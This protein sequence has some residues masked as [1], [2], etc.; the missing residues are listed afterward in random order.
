MADPADTLQGK[1]AS[2]AGKPAQRRP[3]TNR[4][5]R[6]VSLRRIYDSALRLFV[7][8]GY[9]ATTVNDIAA[10]AGLTKGGVYFYIEKKEHL[11][12][13]ML[14]SVAGRYIDDILT[15]LAKKDMPPP[16]K[17]VAFVHSQVQFA[18]AH[19]HEVMLLVMS[20][21]EFAKGGSELSE[22]IEDIY[23]RMRQFIESLL[24]EGR[25]RGVFK[26]G[27]SAPAFASF[28]V[29]AHDGM[30]L[31]WYRRGTEIDGGELVRIYREALL[32]TLA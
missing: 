28:Y 15:A 22:K 2:T 23:Q 9:R 5:L 17:L 12:S 13:Q 16:D 21:V 32:R 24:L 30:M 25:E 10:G 31:E 1:P 27:L 11:M 6:E 4:E 8:Q 26:T 18:Q 19:P 7:E 20:S 29:A 3:Q 14:D